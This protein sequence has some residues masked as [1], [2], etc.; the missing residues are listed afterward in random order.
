ML[1]YTFS[2]EFKIALMKWMIRIENNQREM[3][4]TLETLKSP[5]NDMSP[6]DRNAIL[7]KLGLPATSVEILLN[8]NTML[9]DEENF[10]ALVS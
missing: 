10:K 4:S 5:N 2:D 3:K 6:M 1:S 7:V 8:I 9:T